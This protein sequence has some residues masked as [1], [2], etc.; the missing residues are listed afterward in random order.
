[1]L[2]CTKVK[3][4]YRKRSEDQYQG[5]EIKLNAAED[6]SEMQPLS[7]TASRTADVSLE[8]H[9][10]FERLLADLSARFANVLGD[11]LEEEIES[12][13]KQLLTFLDFDR[14]N[15]GEFTADGWASILCSMAAEG[16][17]RYPPG[18]V[19]KFAAW[20][21]S[22]LRA[23]K[24]VR[25]R[26]IDDLPHGTSEEA[27]YFR[28]SGIRSSV[29]IPLHVGGRIVGFINFSAFRSTR[30]WPDDLI[31]RLKIV[32]EVIAQALVRKRSEAALQASEER[33]RSIFEAS[34]LGISIIDQNLRY[35]ATNPAFQAMLGYTD[36][37]LKNLTAVEVTAEEDRD[38]TRIL[39]NELQQ[40]E[41]HHYQSVKQYRRKN[42]TI[43]WGHVY[44]STVLNA[45][46]G[47]KMFIGTLIDITAT[48]HA[49]DALRAT[50][51]KLA[52]ITRQSTMHEVTATIAHEV[53]QP[54][55]AIVAN[56][57]AALRWLRKI[58]PD[59]AE[60]VVNVNQI[61][62]D[63][64]RA[65]G[66]IASIRGMFKKD[67]HAKV[68]LDV[69]EVIREVLELLHGE[70]NSKRVSVRTKLS[71][72]LPQVLADH[73]QLLQVIL[74]LVTNAVEAMSNN[75]V[76]SRVLNVNS[77]SSQPNEVIIAVE[78][79]GPGIEAKDLDR[80][81]DAFFTTKSQGMGMGL[82]ICR[83]IVESHGGRVWAAGRRPHGSI[84]YIALPGAAVQDVGMR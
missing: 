54:L 15:F 32:G 30:E 59:F 71:R 45:Q 77:K 12:A 57:N 38:V 34:N 8:E 60:A 3:A 16:V 44:A 46:S 36:V 61:V 72:N 74:N 47:A 49:Q 26:S 69:N 5:L 11:Q 76:G 42:G 73:V 53:N 33:W 18:P 56:G 62:N 63:G 14:S 79:S 51:A 84:F 58:P 50:Q 9:L 64:H 35:I 83:S 19:P 55:A 75:P 65:S 2:H 68:L 52:H 1:L 37:E 66:V 29:G 23:E 22:R 13:L 40:G 25:V 70:L 82:S 17:E 39:I 20:Y 67:D 80:I 7:T 27:E 28:Q 48:K 81:F 31:A 4:R 43:M 24:I 21:L 10:T 78:D 6:W 41:R